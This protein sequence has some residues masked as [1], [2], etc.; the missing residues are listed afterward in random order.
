ML[1]VLNSSTRSQTGGM[2][3]SKCEKPVCRLEIL[4]PGKEPGITSLSRLVC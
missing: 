1:T 2:E 3:D 4:G